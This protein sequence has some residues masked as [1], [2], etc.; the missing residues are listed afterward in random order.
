[1]IKR[2]KEWLNESISDEE[3]RLLRQLGLLSVAE[4]YGRLSSEELDREPHWRVE[5]GVAESIDSD[6][7]QTIM[8]E[9][10]LEL[11]E[12]D[13]WFREDSF[14]FESGSANFEPS[15]VHFQVYGDPGRWTK[16]NL[17]ELFWEEAAG[18][19]I[20]VSVRRVD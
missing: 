11:D 18:R 9:S 3:R 4:Y 10:L 15:Y 13:L 17:K 12:P 16:S 7:D 8:L 2:F 6:Y 5:I 1:M 14:Y 19:I 20:F